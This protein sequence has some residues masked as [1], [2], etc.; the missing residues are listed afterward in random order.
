LRRVLQNIFR[1]KVTPATRLQHKLA[2]LKTSR[3]H[4]F[5]QVV[6]MELHYLNEALQSIAP[7]D[8]DRAVKIIARGKRLFVRGGGPSAML[9]DLFELRM[10]RFGILTI[11]MTES[12]RDL[13]EKLQLMHRHDVLL[14]TGFH[15]NNIELAAVIDHAHKIG[16]RIILLTDTLG[17]VYRDKVDVVLSAR[18]GPVSNFHSLT[19]PMAILNALILGVAMRKPHATLAALDQF[20]KL[21]AMYGLDV[22]GKLNS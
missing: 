10:R 17:S 11:S 18:R 21:R 19:V 16:C 3:K 1:A 15:H 5:A 7:A 8:F 12:G 4:I 9:A 13:V 2:D 14:A 22:N 20:Q 6:E